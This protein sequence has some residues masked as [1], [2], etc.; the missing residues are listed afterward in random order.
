[1]SGNCVSRRSFIGAGTGA[2]ALADPG[3]AAAQAVG[4]K[5]SDLSDLTIKQVKV[6]VTKAD[7]ARG[8]RGGRG[9][10]PGERPGEKFPAIVTNSG[11]EGNYTLD[12]RYYHPNWSNLGWLEYAKA[13]LPGK[14]VLDLPALTQRFIRL[15]GSEPPANGFRVK[16]AT[17]RIMVDIKI[18]E[19]ASGTVTSTAV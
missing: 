11:I 3:R 8:G 5:R 17:P 10:P 4:V 13:A 7:R 1:M 19:D 14:N 18:T 6:L 9:G 12:D 16:S 15:R 2:L